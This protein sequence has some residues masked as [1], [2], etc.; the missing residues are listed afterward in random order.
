MA[1]IPYTFSD[2]AGRV[3]ASYLDADFEFVR[4]VSNATGTLPAAHG[5]TGATTLT[6][7]GVVYG[8]GTDPV[9]VTAE[10]ATGTLLGGQ[11]GSPPVFQTGQVAAEAASLGYAVANLAGLKGLTSRPLIVNV[12]EGR[13][14]GT[15]WWDDGSATTPDDGITV[16]CTNGPAGRY[17]RNYLGGRS[18][19]WYGAAA[20]G[21][22][23]DTAAIQATID[24]FGGE[25][26]SIDF[27]PYSYR[28][29]D[30][31][32][33]NAGSASLWGSGSAVTDVF[34]TSTTKHLF[35]F[36]GTAFDCS[37]RNMRMGYEGG[38]TPSAGASIYQTDGTGIIL[39]QGC[40]I[41]RTFRGVEMDNP[42]PLAGVVIIDDTAIEITEEAAVYADGGSQVLISNTTTFHDVNSGKGYGVIL[43]QIGGYYFQNSTFGG[44]LNGIRIDPPAGKGVYH[45]FLT[46]IEL[47][48]NSSTGMIVD[49]S[50][51]GQ[52]VNLQGTNI[53]AAGGLGDGFF[54]GGANLF[55]ASLV[56]ST[57]QKNAGNGAW[58][59][60]GSR[61]SL[62]NFS[63]M[64]NSALSP[65]TNFGIK[66]TGGD[67]HYI[68]GGF[69]GG[70]PGVSD[71][72]GYGIAVDAGFT[73]A[74]RV[75]Q[76][77]VSEGN[78]SGG[79]FNAS[80]STDVKITNCPGFNPRGFLIPSVGASPWTYTA[81][82]SDESVMITGGTVSQIDYEGSN[83]LLS[84]P[85]TLQLPAGKSMTVTY[86]VAPA[87]C[88]IGA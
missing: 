20:D 44:G 24:S 69:S 59:A 68:S 19:I 39:V 82:V 25:R 58:I 71:T 18:P 30:T 28:V 42:T 67:K 22:T 78:I 48:T 27:G 72:Q 47:D 50:G 83:T 70:Y 63:A 54:F 37:V 77:D 60:G 32:E 10:G 1:D 86:S 23:D 46:N 17:K 66:V 79:V 81:G 76:L 74:L 65:G 85:C 12:Q 64:R 62:V 6:D 73:G 8:N 33:I 31:L 61:V 87:V 38:G 43:R 34:T 52:I 53:R 75:D 41:R 11:T 21:V 80:A 29:S 56:N 15:W 16:Q 4:D 5:G 7:N 88:A 55:S 2:R 13:A 57:S 3:P 51:G 49:A 40:R 36:S 35:K 84:S 26:V 14:A 45:G 9:G